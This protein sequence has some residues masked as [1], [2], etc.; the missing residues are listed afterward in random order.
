LLINGKELKDWGFIVANGPK[1]G[2]WTALPA[3]DHLSFGYALGKYFSR[4]GVYKVQWK[5]KSFQSP[6]I[7]FRVL[8]KKE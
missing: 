4:P 1:D 3:K 7:V 8:P 6:E 2:R 5:G